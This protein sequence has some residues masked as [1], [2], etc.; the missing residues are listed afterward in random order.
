M[1]L[2]DNDYSFPFTIFWDCITTFGSISIFIEEVIVH[3]WAMNSLYSAKAAV[4][5][6]IASDKAA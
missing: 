1:S 3:V 5:G 6:A 4:S 2:L